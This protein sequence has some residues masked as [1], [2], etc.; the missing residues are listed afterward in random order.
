MEGK[1]EWGFFGIYRA[2]NT[3]SF[4]EV[5]EVSSK[6]EIPEEILKE[7]IHA[8]QFGSVSNE[9]EINMAFTL[10]MAFEDKPGQKGA[11]KGDI[12]DCQGYCPEI[13]YTDKTEQPEEQNKG[14][15]FNFGKPTPSMTQHIKPLYIKAYMNGVLI[16][17]ILIDNG[18]AVNIL[19]SS[20]LKRLGKENEEL[21][22]TEVIISGFARHKK[23]ARGILPIELS[24]G[25]KS[26][27]V[28]FLIIDGPTSYNALLGRDWIHANKCVPS[29][30]HQQLIIF[31]DNAEVEMVKADDK[32][33]ATTSN[34]MEAKLYEEEIG[35]INARN[36]L[37]DLSE[38]EF[39]DLIMQF[40]G[41]SNDGPDAFG[42]EEDYDS[43]P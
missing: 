35:P 23:K 12:E 43:W 17:R 40:I 4:K 29:S 16:N 11:K 1:I 6:E 21:I 32:P 34:A 33:F 38:G 24:V 5:L 22:P 42:D 15:C 28:A 13:V 19:P 39:N 3:V 9:M 10:P 14:T 20:T 25:A 37:E 8:I 31:N 30:M 7:K 26:T 41:P 27:M 18:A 2:I 36:I